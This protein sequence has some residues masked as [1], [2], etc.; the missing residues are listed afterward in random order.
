MV[1]QNQARAKGRGKDYWQ[2]EVSKLEESGMT[3]AG[4]SREYGVN[5]Y[6]LYKWRSRVRKQV[7]PGAKKAIRKKFVELPLNIYTGQ[8]EERYDIY[9]GTAVHIRIGSVY[10]PETLRNLVDML[11]RQQ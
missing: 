10:N 7:K 8:S 4:Y 1:Q 3:V 11:R 5:A 9:V 2:K 6:R